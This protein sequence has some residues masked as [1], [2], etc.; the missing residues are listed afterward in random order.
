M[1]FK[2]EN[3]AKSAK[4]SSLLDIFNSSCFHTNKNASPM[5]L[6]AAP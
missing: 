6:L 2:K 3:N 4:K 1:I 5:F